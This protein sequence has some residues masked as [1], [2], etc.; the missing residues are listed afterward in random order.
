MPLIR[1]ITHLPD[2]LLEAV[3]NQAETL[4]IPVAEYHRRALL[5]QLHLDAQSFPTPIP[6]S[7]KPS[8]HPFASHPKS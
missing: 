4:G 5:T 7:P 8:P 6:A 1:L 2:R 3:K